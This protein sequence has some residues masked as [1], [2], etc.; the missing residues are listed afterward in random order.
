MRGDPWGICHCRV[1]ALV[2]WAF[3]SC[4]GPDHLVHFGLGCRDAAHLQFD[5]KKR[6]DSGMLTASHRED[7]RGGSQSKER[8]DAASD[9]TGTSSSHVC[10]WSNGTGLVMTRCRHRR[11]SILEG[12]PHS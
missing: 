10:V 11:R 9:A 6:L 4:L 5:V 1:V 12:Q 8:E 7:R 2:L 3:G